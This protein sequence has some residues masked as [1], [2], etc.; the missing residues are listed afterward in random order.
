ML[1]GVLAAA[2]LSPV[3]D[4][5]VALSRVYKQGEKAEY[6]VRSHL[7][8]ERRQ[9]GL[10]TF[11]PEEMDI[12]YNFTYEVTKMQA[13]GVAVLRYKRPTITEIEGETYDAPPKTKVEKVNWDLILTM[14][15]INEML[16]VKDLTPK[17]DPKKGGSKVFAPNGTPTQ[18]NPFAFTQELYRL[19]L[20]IGSLDSSMDFSPK[21]P[22]DDVKPGDTWHKTVGYQPQ[23]LKDSKGKSAVQRLDYTYTYKGIVQSGNRK[24]HRIVAT[25]KLDTNVAEFVNQMLNMT[26]EDTHLKEIA[27]KLDAS[28]DYDLD[29]KTM[30][31]IKGVAKSIGSIKIVITDF[32]NEPVIEERIKG[33]TLLAIVSAK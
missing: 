22:L 15:P 30:R 19:S 20:F 2:V 27:L 24:V 3:S 23:K 5:P 13:D 9:R 33:E 7:L 10:E 12:N 17:K 1:V 18:I 31:T 6:K 25:L 32:P 8:V 21:L 26:A 11:M 16:E 29:L 14:S 28:I 4:A